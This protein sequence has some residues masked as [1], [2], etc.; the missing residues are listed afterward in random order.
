[1]NDIVN[2]PAAG[3]SDQQLRSRHEEIR[4]GLIRS[5]TA[6]TVALLSS[7]GLALAAV[8]YGFKAE[9]HALAA[10][11]SSLRTT[12]ELWNSQ[13]A[14]AR[15]LRWSGQM[16][17]RQEGLGAI[18]N[19]TAIRP[20]PELRDEVI[21]TLAL[22]DIQVGAFWQPMPPRVK[23]AACAPDR[24]HYAWGDGSGR[25]EVFRTAD[26]REAG[27]FAVPNRSVM[28]L[29]FSPDGRY[30]AA[31]FAGGALRVWDT[32]QSEVAFEAVYPVSGFNEHSVCFHPREPW[33]VASA[34][35]GPLRVVD[36][37]A[38]QEMARL[39]VL[40]PVAAQAFN[41]EGTLLAAAVETRIELWD[42]SARRL[43]Q[44]LDLNGAMTTLAWHP[45]GQ[46]L[47]G[48]HA[49]GNLTLV[50]R[51]LGRRRTL[52]GHTMV[53]NR[54]L[55]D[56]RGEVL[57]STSWDGTTRFWD[58]RSGRS[59]LTTEAGYALAFDASGETISY[60][61]E[62][63]GLGEWQYLPAVGFTRL[64]VPVG[65]SDRVLGVDFSSEARWV[66]G[67]TG[68]GVHLWHRASGRHAAFLPLKDA[69][70]AAFA[71]DGQSVV[72][73]TGAGLFRLPL[74][75]DDD[76]NTVELGPAAA[77]PGTE[78]QGFW[79]GCITHGQ[80]KWFVTSSATETAIVPLEPEGA[81]QRVP[82][83]R[84]RRWTA[85]SPDLRFLV[86]SAWK[87]G[88]TQ[89]WDLAQGTARAQLQDEG[90][91][92]GFSADGR[93]LGVG[94]ST[95]FRF[96]DTTTWQVVRRVER[97]AASALSGILA[98]SPDG[99][100]VALSHSIRQVRLLTAE[101]GEVLA[102]LGAPHLE[103]ITS[104]SFSRD[105]QH[106]AVATDN[107]EVR[108]WDLERLRRELSGMGLGWHD[109]GQATTADLPPAVVTR[110]R[111]ETLPT[112]LRHSRAPWLALTGAGLALWFAFY[113]IRYHH[114]LVTAYA[115][116]ET[117]AAQ[118][119]RAL[120]EARDQLLHSQKMKALGTLAA[121]IAHDFN[122]LLSVIRMSGQLVA[123]QVHPAGLTK[124]N[125]DAIEEAVRQGK[126]IVRSILG[127]SRQ[128][129]PDQ[130]SYKVNLV[131]SEMLAMLTKQFLSGIVLTLELDPATP[132]VSGD[133]GRLEQ[134][135]LNLVVNAAEAM[136]GHGKLL[137]ALR[138]CAQAAGCWLA[139]RPAPSY[140]ELSIQDSGPGIPPEILPR[141]FEPFFTTK[142]GATEHGTGLGLTTVYALA[143]QDGLGLAV[144]SVPGRG[145][146]FRV[147]IPVGPA[148]AP[149]APA[150]L[151]PEDKP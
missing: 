54:V 41:R 106:L 90:G 47:V 85:V 75:P 26:R 30:L 33:L 34:S 29:D 104:L 27:G 9:Q 67:T 3:L 1:M 66:A 17:R 2:H 143:Q 109:R 98:F 16:G 62:Q 28:S 136:N 123:R 131:V 32:K 86:A 108:L 81:V 59:L 92:L 134:I 7:I 145:T 103:R 80:G 77:V 84:G 105:G 18:R 58:A 14:R 71:L 115:A 94:G 5:N 39:P 61:K 141:I 79:L 40:G 148:P 70:R 45:D 69:Q 125:L 8:F 113:N 147:L 68:E 48:A 132:P 78:G 91:S 93:R 42:F 118:R 49:D 117:I 60:Y 43:L 140:L 13:L 111:S 99:R 73:S 64:A 110:A 138:P 150:R 119:H 120:E 10:R 76:G 23:T 151:A 135:L 124:E 31:R 87:G 100:Y 95:E 102:N 127:Y 46:I 20:A 116:V 126:E 55:F 72:A 53:A 4:R 63:I 21:A 25:V 22:I 129:G 82:W 97:D 88:G 142:R 57:I 12:A 146:L 89:I 6:T 101:A 52:E 38:R 15:A 36:L 128:A 19:A 24:R 112:L 74:R 122:N 130:Q 114:R 133:A 56:P 50:D 96:Y 137:L 107:G 44:K 35:A 11:Q 51:R 121:G 83:L 37:S 139:P 149:A 65:I 144:E